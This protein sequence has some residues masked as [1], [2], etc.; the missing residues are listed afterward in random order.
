MS[1]GVPLSSHAA[2]PPAPSHQV[3]EQAAEWYALLR[4]GEATEGDR[5]R[6]QSWLERKPDHSQ[7]WSYVETIGRSFAPIQ[8]TH[9]PRRTADG[10]WTANMRI[11]QRRRLLAGIGA[12]TVPGLLSWAA[13]SYTPL[14][15]TT[16]AW[17]ADHHSST[18]EMREIVLSDGTRIWLNTASAFNEDYRSGLRRLRLIAGE[19]LIETAS[20][21]QRPFFVDTPQGRLRALGTRFT[22][23][24]DGEETFLGVYEGAV[25]VQAGASIR[26]VIQA[27]Q[28]TR[29]TVAG[30]SS[31]KPADVARE[32]WSRGVLVVQDMA[33]NEVV[34]ELRRYHRGHLGLAPEVAGLRVFGSFPLHDMDGALH[35]LASALP[36]RIRRTLPWWVS[37]EA[38]R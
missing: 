17:M 26:S 14:S 18:G 24:L 29:F 38:R 20:D 32:A 2:I 35:M 15:A 27:G 9:D 33:L 5:A 12:I 11:A 4:S 22:V 1:C 36:I 8:S 19:I 16:I 31:V 34:S 28:Q 21:P 25:E 7:A 13:W 23:R 37:I 10:L 30:P 3:M 6:W